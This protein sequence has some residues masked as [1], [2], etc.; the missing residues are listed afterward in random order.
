MGELH[1]QLF[2]ARAKGTATRQVA[3][4]M[5][6]VEDRCEEMMAS[7][8]A[9]GDD[10]AGSLRCALEGL[11]A[12]VGR[13]HDASL[14]QTAV[15]ADAYERALV[16]PSVRDAPKHEELLR[17]LEHELSLQM[18]LSLS[19]PNEWFELLGRKLKLDEHEVAEWR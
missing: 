13:Q 17:Q 14:A 19:R 16:A 1:T 9:V 18:Q 12:E 3:E 8:A 7:A 10:A 15:D 2:V 11:L 6:A 4:V 5:R